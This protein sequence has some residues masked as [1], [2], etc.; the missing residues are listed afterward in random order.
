MFTLAL[1]WVVVVSAN[2]WESSNTLSVTDSNFKSIIGQDKHLVLE[3]YSPACVYCKQIKQ[4]YEGLWSHFNDPQSNWYSG[5]VSVARS[6]SLENPQ[7]AQVYSVSS[8]PTILFFAAGSTE[9]LSKFSGP[10][11]KYT[12]IKWVNELLPPESSWQESTELAKE[13]RQIKSVLNEEV[14][15]NLQRTQSLESKLDN[16]NSDIN[17]RNKVESA[18]VRLNPTHALVFALLG[19]GV[20]CGAGMLLLKVKFKNY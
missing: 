20:G 15:N 16:L 12:F 4:D 7:V 3:F 19:F 10:R 14:L 6:N 18:Q 5:S 8:F 13:L 17:H 1:S 9:P 11:N 2:W